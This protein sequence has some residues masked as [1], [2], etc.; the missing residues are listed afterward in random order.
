MSYIYKII[1]VNHIITIVWTTVIVSYLL[2]ENHTMDIN[3]WQGVLIAT[4]PSVIAGCF[5]YNIAKKG[6]LS[7]IDKKLETME[8]RIGVNDS[9]TLLTEIN[10]NFSSVS[11]KLGTQDHCNKSLS[12]QHDEIQYLISLKSKEQSGMF[13]DQMDIIKEIN[14]R[15]KAEIRRN[16]QIEN[17]L[18]QQTIEAKQISDSFAYLTR[19]VE[20]LEYS[21]KESEEIS[22]EKSKKIGRLEG[23]IIELEQKLSVYE[24][25]RSKPIDR[26]KRKSPSL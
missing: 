17:S 16:K 22:A 7:D 19:R 21:L 10:D 26:P 11:S 4:I 9:K 15:E 5:S 1:F 3:F 8:R 6:K 23:E 18:S 2:E 14:E 24:A 13:A 25:E 20:K 12:V